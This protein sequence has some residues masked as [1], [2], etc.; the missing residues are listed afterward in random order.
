MRDLP[1]FQMLNEYLFKALADVPALSD[2]VRGRTFEEAFIDDARF[3]RWFRQT[4]GDLAGDLRAPDVWTEI[5][6]VIKGY[7][8][9]AKALK[10]DETRHW[11]W[12][13]NVFPVGQKAR[14]LGASPEIVGRV[15]SV[16]EKHGNAQYE[17]TGDTGFRRLLH[18]DALSVADARNEIGQWAGT[19]RDEGLAC[20]DQILRSAGFGDCPDGFV[21]FRKTGLT[22]GEYLEL[23]DAQSIHDK[24]V[25]KRIYQIYLIYEDWK[26][27]KGLVDGNDLARIA[28]AWY[29]DPEHD[30]PFGTVVVDECQDFTEMQLLAMKKLGRNE[31]GMILAGD[32]HQM[33]N[34]TFFD[35]DR[36]Q[37]LFPLADGRLQ[38]CHLSFNYRNT[39]A[40]ADFS[41]RIAKKRREWIGARGLA[42][43][44][45][46]Q[47]EGEGDRP[48]FWAVGQGEQSAFLERQLEDPTFRV[49][50]Y[51]DKDRD[52]VVDLAKDQQG[53]RDRVVTIRECKGLEFRKVLCYNLLGRY[54]DEWA[55]IRSGR[56]KHDE[57][58]RYH[59]NSV[60]VA[61][62]RSLSRLGFLERD[63][64]AFRDNPWLS[65]DRDFWR[66]DIP[67]D[68]WP[69][70]KSRR[71]QD[72]IE[73]GDQSF[74]SADD[75]DN[76]EEKYETA[77][78]FYRQAEEWWSAKDPVDM[79]DIR[80]RIASA[81][82]K[83]ARCREEDSGEAVMYCLRHGGS[84]IQTDGETPL[85]HLYENRK[86]GKVFDGMD[87]GDIKQIFSAF[88]RSG[89]RRLLD[90]FLQLQTIAVSESARKL[91]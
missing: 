79:A 71:V 91:A 25:R 85:E 72:A 65:E 2:I 86:A 81:M 6:G 37:A 4:Q 42:G 35:P 5:K 9:A 32:Q 36:I 33:I 50:V 60:Y 46:E 8:G 39:K 88:S 24:P 41:N 10:I 80:K 87:E 48:D 69:T 66:T 20:M 75:S 84:W 53:M 89:D 61:A 58:Y 63:E 30:R 27:R 34:P 55:F 12:G 52:T 7:L 74:E 59:F 31:N 13:H 19:D 23:P 68:A 3:R 47:S 44:Q 26:R 11:S 83:I 62:T 49:L 64:A 43:E 40:I 21:D 22:Q 29:S 15:W 67:A 82:L 76:P 57:R 17:G 78:R 18:A 90:E 73:S 28:A 16:L 51:D 1:A 14:N 70:D 38:T 77:L 56:A 54:P 45:D